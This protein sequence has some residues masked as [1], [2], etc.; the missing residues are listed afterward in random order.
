M[1]AARGGFVFYTSIRPVSIPEGILDLP[2]AMTV[3][4][5]ALIWLVL[6]VPL[7]GAVMIALIPALTRRAASMNSTADGTSDPS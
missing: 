3:T 4:A 7:L 6:P 5:A 1:L 2:W